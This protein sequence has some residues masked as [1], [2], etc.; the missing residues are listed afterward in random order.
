[1][2][3]TGPRAGREVVQIYAGAAGPDT[4][5]RPPRWLAG[6]AAVDAGPG[7]ACTVTIGL[8]ERTFQI[9][10]AGAAGGG[11]QTVSGEYVIEAARSRADVRLSATV[12][13]G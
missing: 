4:A 2:R 9:W 11:W 5:D 10:A 13:V 12:H 7:E 6:F 3:N 8:P 1:M